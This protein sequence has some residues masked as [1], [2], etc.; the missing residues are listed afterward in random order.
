MN[1]QTLCDLRNCC[2]NALHELYPAGIS[3]EVISDIREVL[4]LDVFYVSSSFYSVSS[5][6]LRFAKSLEV[7][8]LP[9]PEELDGI[10]DIG[11][12]GKA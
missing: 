12:V 7:D 3:N 1:N 10:V 5:C 6:T 11:I 9:F 4:V 8:N 2:E